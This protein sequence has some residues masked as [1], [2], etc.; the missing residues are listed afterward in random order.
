MPVSNDKI[1]LTITLT[2]KQESRLKSVIEETGCSGSAIVS[3]A[4]TAW[5]DEW[6]ARKHRL[7]PEQ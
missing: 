2:T 3:L 5:L 6:E 4:L 1:R 7:N